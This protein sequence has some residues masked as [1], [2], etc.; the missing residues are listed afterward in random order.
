MD[1]VYTYIND[2]KA[3]LDLLD[4]ALVN[5]VIGVLHRAR[6]NQR[7][8]F[9]MGNGGSASTASHFVCDLAKNT[10]ASDRAHF[11]VIGLA[12]SMAILSAYANDEGYE[13]VFAHQLASL[14]QPHDVVIGISTSGKSPNVL[15]A[16]ELANASGATT[17]GF[18]G[19]DAGELGAMVDFHL[20]VPSNCIE[21]VEDIHLMLEHLI[22]KALRE[23]PLVKTDEIEDTGNGQQ[24]ALQSYTEGKGRLVPS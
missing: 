18:T 16:I 5:E 17:V 19:F 7:Q 4:S 8:I 22:T 14:V 23:M 12:D 21:H 13:N 3:T 20:H 1:P 6:L 11:R 10:R 2:L 9:I 24:P 15:R